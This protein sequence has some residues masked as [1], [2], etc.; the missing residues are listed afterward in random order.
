MKVEPGQG[1]KE[2]ACLSSEMSLAVM[3]EGGGV[4]AAK[5]VEDFLSSSS[6]SSS[7]CAKFVLKSA[8]WKIIATTGLDCAA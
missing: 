7:S 2:E 3:L 4:K 5:V 1:T 6:S 8:P